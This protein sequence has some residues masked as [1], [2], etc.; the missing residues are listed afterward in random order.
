MK[1]MKSTFLSLVIIL[2]LI[3]S[4]NLNAYTYNRVVIL[5]PAVGDIFKKLHI[6]NTVVGI[7]K[8][9]RGFKNAT[10][11]GSHIRPNIEIISSLHPDLIIISST[12]FFNKS[13]QKNIKAK[14]YTYNP[15]KLSQI[16][17]TLNDFGKMFNKEDLANKLIVK[18]KN[19]LSNVKK[20][21]KKPKVVFEVMQ[22]PYIVSGK[23]DIVN[24]IIEKAGGI[25][26]VKVNKKHVR[27]SYEKVLEA[28]P[29]FYLYQ[30]GPMN[31]NPIPPEKREVLK[32]L[33]AKFIKIDERAFSRPNTLSFDNVLKLNK[34]FMEK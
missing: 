29:D 20:L 22:L 3:I 15:Y 8:H 21:N 30:I 14:V 17:D 31:K 26:I 16:L 19:K 13:L 18:L 23:K 10:K 2:S 25:N 1:F 12:K 5:A 4:V 11:V 33:K 24:D 28:K 6:S 27:Y 7:T 34:I 9:M 32:T